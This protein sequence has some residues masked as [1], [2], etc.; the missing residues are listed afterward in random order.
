MPTAKPTPT[1]FDT[2]E[3]FR[4]GLKGYEKFRDKFEVDNVNK[5]SVVGGYGHDVGTKRHDL[6]DQP[7]SEA[8]A[9]QWLDEDIAA[10]S[11]AVQ[12]LVNPAVWDR[13]TPRQRNAGIALTLNVGEG[14]LGKSRTLAKLNAGDVMGAA[15]E[16]LGFNHSGGKQVEG[17]S[18]RRAEEVRQL[19]GDDIN[20]IMPNEHY[21]QLNLWSFPGQF[22]QS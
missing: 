21:R 17:L 3:S 6:I 7:V 1:N 4:E 14:N 10:K 20:K 13:M 11:A 2:P 15:E 9:E 5:K 8:Q 19:I 12:K 22:P 18:R 16:W